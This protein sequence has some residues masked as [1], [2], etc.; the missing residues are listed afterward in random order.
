MSDDKAQK[1]KRVAAENGV[2]ECIHPQREIDHVLTQVQR[3]PRRCCRS[4]RCSHV[5]GLHPSHVS[6]LCGLRG[7]SEDHR[8]THDFFADLI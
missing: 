8:L 2:Y 4:G 7:T 6:P 3:Q 1:A 5:L